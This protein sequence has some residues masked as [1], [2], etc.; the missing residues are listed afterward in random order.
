MNLRTADT[1]A[2]RLKRESLVGF[3][4]FEATSNGAAIERLVAFGKDVE[5][6]ATVIFGDKHLTVELHAIEGGPE[7]HFIENAGWKK[8]SAAEAGQG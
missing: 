1:F 8:V 5:T 6:F 2:L 7:R 3:K 4:R